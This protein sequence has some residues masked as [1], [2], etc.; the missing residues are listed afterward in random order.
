MGAEDIAVPSVLSTFPARPAPGGPGAYP[1]STAARPVRTAS[2][3][4]V[5]GT[6]AGASPAPAAPP[7]RPVAPP[8]PPP[9]PAPA[10]ALASAPLPPERP[11]FIA[12]NPNAP[13]PVQMFE[14][15]V[16]DIGN[17]VERNTRGIRSSLND[18]YG[19]YYG[20][21]MFAYTPQS[22][23]GQDA[24][25]FANMDA[26]MRGPGAPGLFDM[27]DRQFGGMSRGGSTAGAII[28]G[29]FGGPIGGLV[30]GLTGGIAGEA[31]GFGRREARDGAGNIIDPQSGNIFSRV[32]D[33]LGNVF[34]GGEQA[35]SG[36][37]SAAASG[38]PVG[39]PGGLG[40]MGGMQSD[41]FGNDI[42]TLYN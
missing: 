35:S 34:D 18:R 31:M 24:L 26:A 32:G 13:R 10:P 12:N 21:D 40:G 7:S 38:A 1:A 39:N 16:A 19:D 15:G 14:R 41:P 6:I 37:N 17:F 8:A 42:S 23:G 5:P 36:G 9:R 25:S 27:Y 30:G 2:A 20:G 33:F 3:A 11:A 4:A 29:M 22:Y 28:G